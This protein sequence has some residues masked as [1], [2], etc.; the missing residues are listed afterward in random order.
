MLQK[1]VSEVKG[2]IKELKKEGRDPEQIDLTSTD[3]A[4]TLQK[5][6]SNLHQSS[7]VGGDS[8]ASDLLSAMNQLAWERDLDL[9]GGAGGKIDTVP[10]EAEGTPSAHKPSFLSKKSS[11]PSL[12]ASNGNNN[13]N[14]G[15]GAKAMD[16]MFGAAGNKHPELLEMQM[17][18]RHAHTYSPGAM[19]KSA[20]VS[21][22]GPVL[23]KPPNHER[24]NKRGGAGGGGGVGS[25]TVVTSRPP[26]A[27]SSS[28]GSKDSK[29]SAF[30]EGRRRTHNV[31]GSLSSLNSTSSLLHHS[32][33]SRKDQ[34]DT[35]F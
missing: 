9:E 6:R 19:F 16:E 12:N 10:E 2:L 25:G 13:A 33:D 11:T 26:S 14:T 23:N 31:M 24:K 8:G 1:L 17:A 4:K 7:T 5:R 18:D 20:R 15:A 3:V 30:S 34:D 32:L 29:D 28:G 27:R 35:D 22:S 21:P